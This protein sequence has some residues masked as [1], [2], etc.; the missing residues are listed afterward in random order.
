MSDAFGPRPGQRGEALGRLLIAGA[1][2][3]TAVVQ[4][5]A[6][7]ND[8]HAFNEDWPPH[9]RFHDLVA[10]GM[11]QGCCATSMYLLWTKRGD[12]RLNTAV[13]A[14]LP[15]TFWVPF[16]PAHFVSGSSFDDGT[17]HHPS[18]ELPRIGPFRI[19]PN[20]AA[21]AVEL[22]LLA[23]GWW[24]FRRAAKMRE[25]LSAPS[26]SRGGGRRSPHR[27]VRPPGRAA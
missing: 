27:D 20:A 9:A 3:S 8:S 17:A 13:A 6:D 24:L 5:L 19:F 1:V 22:S 23:L 26:R 16:F 15:A 10:L 12:R 25:V 14:L 7:L 4:P 2:V 18:P 21:S 11:L